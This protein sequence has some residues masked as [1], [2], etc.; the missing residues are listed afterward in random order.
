MTVNGQDDVPEYTPRLRLQVLYWH[1][2]IIWLCAPNL[3]SI[4]T[5]LLRTN[6]TYR[7]HAD[8]L[9][10]KLHTNYDNAFDSVAQ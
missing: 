7:P 2:R 4:R 3:F 5:R 8:I 10:C 9:V 1:L 6:T